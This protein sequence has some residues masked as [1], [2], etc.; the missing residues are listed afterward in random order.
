MTLYRYTSSGA[1]RYG[2]KGRARDSTVYTEGRADPCRA[3][4]DVSSTSAKSSSYTTRSSSQPRRRWATRQLAT[5][6]GRKKITE[7]KMRLI[8]DAL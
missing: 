8:K 3:M 7:M 1:L 4:C 6:R 5:R 2:R